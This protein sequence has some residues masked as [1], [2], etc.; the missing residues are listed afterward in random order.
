MKPSHVTPLR[1]HLMDCHIPI[2]RL[3]RLLSLHEARTYRIVRGQLE[4]TAA[5]RAEIADALGLPAAQLFDPHGTRDLPSREAQVER[6]VRW[7][8]TDEGRFL[9]SRFVDAIEND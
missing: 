8:A 9:L 2:R 7:L 3:A 1:Q 5:E 6:L 4:P